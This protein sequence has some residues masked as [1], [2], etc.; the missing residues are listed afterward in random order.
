[1]LDT[2][3]K[4]ILEQV[5]RYRDVKGGEHIFDRSADHKKAAD[6]AKE[7]MVLLKNDGALPLPHSNAK[8][9]FIGAFA[10]DPRIQGGGSSHINTKN[11]SNA[12]DS[13]AKYSDVSYAEGYERES[14]DTNPALLEEAVQLAADSDV[15]V[16]FAGLPDSFE[17]EGYDRKHMRMPDC[18]NELIDEICKV[19][20]NVIVVLH[21]GSPVEMPWNDKVSAVLEVYLC[22][23]ATGE[24]TTDILFGKA[25]P[26]GKLAETIPMK[27][28]DTPCYLTFPGDRHAEYNEGVFVG[29]RYYDK[30]EMAVRY[31]FGHGLSYTTF[32]Y[33]DIKLSDTAV[34][35]DDILTVN[36]VI[37]NTGNCAGKEIVQ[38]YVADK[39]GFA[40]RPEKELKDFIKI[41]LQ[42]GESKTVTFR[43]DKRAFSYYNEELCD[44]YAPNG[45]YDIMIAS[46]SRDIRLTAEVTHKTAVK[47]PF[48]ATENTVFGEFMDYAEGKATLD[49]LFSKVAKGLL[50]GDHFEPEAVR[51]MIGSMPLRQIRSFGG[52]SDELL[53]QAVDMLNKDFGGFKAQM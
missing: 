31:P 4:R 42:P 14:N 32:E 37:T 5:Y 15:A 7:C 21:N 13:A 39:S 44:W 20:E 50:G 17:S 12:L 28:S 26:C 22:G 51:S 2:A 36:A 23:E 24:A 41:E 52:I 49:L 35:D 29:Y 48:I 16:I 27:L 30:K 33:S 47:L 43:L 40:V 46:S 10:K 3:V 25:N 19:Q 53:Q 38:L 9:A 45:K 18:Q 34:G 8:I 1:M 11:I 6:I